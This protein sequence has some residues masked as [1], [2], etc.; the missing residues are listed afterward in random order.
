MCRLKEFAFTLACLGLFTAAQRQ[1]GAQSRPDSGSKTQKS[2]E[3]APVPRNAQGEPQLDDVQQASSLIGKPIQVPGSPGAKV[4]DVLLDL[5]AGRVA[6]VLAKENGPSFFALPPA[7]LGFDA[8]TKALT[9]KATNEQLNAASWDANHSDR[10]DLDKIYQLFV[11]QPYTQK[12]QKTAP[13]RPERKLVSVTKVQGVPVH[14]AKG[15]PLGKVSD[16]GIALAE[17]LIAYVAVSCSCFDDASGKLFPVPLTA[18]V[19]KPDA[20]AWILEL[21][22]DVLANTPTFAEK[23]WPEKIDRGWVEYVH[24][25]YG[26]SPFGGAEHQ[27]REERQ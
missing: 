21:P 4:A 10:Q 9:T 14:N 7:A 3:Q 13:Q 25:R 24:V 17:G 18:F 19:I 16:V 22:L 11:Q 5:N 15:E 12:Q 20:K 6:L 26:R 1:E 8:K 2:G 23:Q 27:L